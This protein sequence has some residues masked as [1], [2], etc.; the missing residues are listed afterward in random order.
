MNI[1]MSSRYQIEY[2]NQKLTDMERRM[3]MLA[4]SEATIERRMDMLAGINREEENK[5]INDA[6][7]YTRRFGLVTDDP[8][9]MKTLSDWRDKK[10][11]IIQKRKE[12]GEN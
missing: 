3:D 4:R 7:N 11:E 1:D 2:L 5:I 8:D 6:N 9:I 12:R 10:E